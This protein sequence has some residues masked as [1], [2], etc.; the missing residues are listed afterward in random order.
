[1]EMKQELE[2]EKKRKC[3]FFAF[4]WFSGFKK[5]FD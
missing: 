1:M 5:P 4:K 2:K 3:F